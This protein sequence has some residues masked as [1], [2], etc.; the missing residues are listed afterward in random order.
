MDRILGDRGAAQP[1]RAR[2]LRARARRDL[3]G[4]AGRHVRRRRALQLSDAEAAQLL[5]RRHGARARRG[6]RGEGARGMVDALPWPSEKRV[7]DRLLMG[8]LQRIFI[9]PWVFS[10]SLVPGAVGLGAHRRQPGRVPVGED[11]LARTRCPTQYTER[12]PNVQAAIGLEA[13]EAARRVDRRRPRRTPAYVNRALGG[14][15]GH[16]GAARAAG[17]HARLL[18]VLRATARRAPARRARRPLRAARHRHRD[19]ARG[20]AAGHGAV[21]AR[22]TAE[23]DGARRA[24][25]AMQIPVYSGL[26]PRADRARRRDVVRGVLANHA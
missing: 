11:S 23:A 6:A 7:T 5:R 1:D 8:R 21:P 10:I 20:R 25:Q 14:I 2:G 22:A 19:A 13:L 3:Q 4:Q 16:P 17:S 12:F 18:P 9:K 24:A 26:T 15:A